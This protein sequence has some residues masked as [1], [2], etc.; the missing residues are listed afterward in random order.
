MQEVGLVSGSIP[1]ARQIF[2]LTGF[3]TRSFQPVLSRYTDC[4]IGRVIKNAKLYVFS[5][6][7]K[8][9]YQ[10]NTQYS[11][12]L[13]GILSNFCTVR[14]ILFDSIIVGKELW[15]MTNHELD[16]RSLHQS[17][18]VSVKRKLSLSGMANVRTKGEY[19]DCG[20]GVG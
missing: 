16:Q 5:H 2:S 17:I 20:V 13:R 14:T 18:A 8:D 4:A 15:K 7:Y 10:T 9:F 3:N 1:K 12:V 19:T 6:L 11:N